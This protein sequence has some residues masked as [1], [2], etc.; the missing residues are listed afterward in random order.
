MSKPSTCWRPGASRPTRPSYST[1]RRPRDSSESDRSQAGLFDDQAPGRMDDESSRRFEDEPLGFHERVRKGYLELA[2]DEPDR[3]IVID[4]M[5]DPDEVARAIWS[6]VRDMA[7]F[8]E[9]VSR[10]SA[11]PERPMALLDA[12]DRLTPA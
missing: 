3:W 5:T 7:E 4:G 6:A 10:R 8:D 11:S 9:L 12:A 1:V 2:R